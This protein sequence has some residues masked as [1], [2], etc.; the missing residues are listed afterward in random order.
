MTHGIGYAAEA[1]KREDS[2]Y[3]IEAQWAATALSRGL[4]RRK[5][6]YESTAVRTQSKDADFL[7]L[8][9]MIGTASVEDIDYRSKKINIDPDVYQKT[10]TILTEMCAKIDIQQSVATRPSADVLVDYGNEGTF[11]VRHYGGMY[12]MSLR[13]DDRFSR[14][15]VRDMSAK[16]HI[17]HSSYI[18][19]GLYSESNK[20][21]DCDIDMRHALML[22][23]TA[24]DMLNVAHDSRYNLFGSTTIS[25]SGATPKQV[26]DEIL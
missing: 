7:Q 13:H 18:T 26:L 21:T 4:L 15:Y 25:R 16:E 14:L 1:S 22:H 9:E 12:A 6:S 10:A 5:T 24:M 2:S 20:P 23:N 8:S 19:T 11:D 17:W 3:T